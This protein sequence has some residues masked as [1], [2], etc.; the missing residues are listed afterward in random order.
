MFIATCYLQQ[1]YIVGDLDWEVVA[2]GVGR[3]TAQECR[4]R[5]RKFGLIDEARETSDCAKDYF[6]RE[7]PGDVSYF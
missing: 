1:S 6:E 4:D 5:C 2:K 7:L 3:H